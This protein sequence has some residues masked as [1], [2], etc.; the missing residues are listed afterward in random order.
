VSWGHKVGKDASV[1]GAH[2]VGKEADMGGGGQQTCVVEVTYVVWW[3]MVPLNGSCFD[4]RSLLISSRRT[5]VAFLPSMRQLGYWK[6][7]C[8]RMDLGGWGRLGVRLR[9]LLSR[10]FGS[11][12]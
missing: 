11:L 4:T 5:C 6:L 9:Q 12:Q 8:A 1:R 2:G 7:Q 10:W 3:W